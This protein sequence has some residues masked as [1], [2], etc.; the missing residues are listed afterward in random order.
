MESRGTSRDILGRMGRY[1][2]F[3][4]MADVGIRVQADSPEDL[5]LTAALGVMAWI[6]SPPGGQVNEE[7][8]EVNAADSE[9]LLVR[10]LQEILCGFH[11]RRAYLNG[12]REIKV[13]LDQGKVEALIVSSLWDEKRQGDYQ[14]VKA[15]TYHQLR[16]EHKESSWLASII[17]DI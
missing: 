13:D 17:L 5:F 6:G 7:R 4:H 12:A 9:E 1:E 14:E 16:I 3:D 10:W 15:V 11:L 8:I 2:F